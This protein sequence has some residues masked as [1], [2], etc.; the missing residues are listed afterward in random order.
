MNWAAIEAYWPVI[1][2]DAALFACI[3]LILLGSLAYE[4]RQEG[5]R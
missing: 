4:I 2:A 5:A 1:D 3:A